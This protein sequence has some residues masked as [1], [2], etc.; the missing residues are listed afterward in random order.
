MIRA[1]R[2][3]ELKKLLTSKGISTGLHYPIPIHLQPAYSYLGYKKGDFPITE[4]VAEEILSLPMY[5]ELAKNQ[6]QYVCECIS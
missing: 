5:P 6:I 2:R 3:N 1:K 4:E